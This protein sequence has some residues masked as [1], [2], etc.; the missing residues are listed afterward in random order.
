LQNLRAARAVQTNDA[1]FQRGL[2][3]C[4]V[5]VGQIVPSAGLE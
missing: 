1:G 4:G 2:S 3:W 5:G